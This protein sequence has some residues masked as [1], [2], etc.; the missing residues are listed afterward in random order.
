MVVQAE[1][2]RS[3]SL[4][5]YLY[6]ELISNSFQKRVLIRFFSDFSDF[7]ADPEIL[8]FQSNLRFSIETDSKNSFSR[9]RSIGSEPGALE[10]LAEL[11]MSRIRNE[12]N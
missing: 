6:P 2:T 11:E 12:Q 10:N 9:S 8:F 1:P 5:R 3:V 4:Y 7:F